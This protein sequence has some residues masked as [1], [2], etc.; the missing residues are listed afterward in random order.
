R[1]MSRARKSRGVYWRPRSA[2]AW[3]GPDSSVR[4]TAGATRTASCFTSRSVIGAVLE[5]ALRFR[6][7]FLQKLPGLA[8]GPRFRELVDDLG[9]RDHGF[10]LLARAV[11]LAGR[12]EQAAGLLL[13]PELASRIE[14]FARAPAPLHHLVA[15]RIVLLQVL[16]REREV[17]QLVQV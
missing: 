17:V 16:G 1:A 4:K 12:D 7:P 3:P 5:A 8:G 2:S 14:L 11:Q 6:L 13:D 10:L 9:Q 15:D